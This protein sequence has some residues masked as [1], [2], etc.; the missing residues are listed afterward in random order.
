MQIMSD[1][2]LNQNGRSRPLCEFPQW[3]KYVGDNPDDAKSFVC[4][5]S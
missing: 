1:S 5:G 3:P 4:S 2:A